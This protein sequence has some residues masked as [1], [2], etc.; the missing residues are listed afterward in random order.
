[1]IV[2]TTANLQLFW[3]TVIIKMLNLNCNNQ[4]SVIIFN[5]KINKIT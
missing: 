2:K 5:I 1:M 4:N 3:K